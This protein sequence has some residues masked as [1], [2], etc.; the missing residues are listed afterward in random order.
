MQKHRKVLYLNDAN[1]SSTVLHVAAAKGYSDYASFF[2]EVDKSK[3][4]RGDKSG[5]IPLHLAC[6]NI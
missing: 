1:N 2:I 3:V 6:E 5:K 4:N